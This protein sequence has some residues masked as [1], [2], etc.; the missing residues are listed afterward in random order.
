MVCAQGEEVG[1]LG[2]VLNT[3]NLFGFFYLLGLLLRVA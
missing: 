1:D 3:K 2:P